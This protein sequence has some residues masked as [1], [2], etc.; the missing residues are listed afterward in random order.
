MSPDAAGVIDA[1]PL[2][3]TT[4]EFLRRPVIGHVIDGQ[5]FE[6]TNDATVNVFDPS[7]GSLIGQSAI[8]NQS[9][10]NRA[11][12][13]A[14]QAFDSGVWRNVHPSEREKRM[15]RFADLIGEH[16]ST[17]AQLDTLDAGIQSAFT[18]FYMN[19][20]VDMIHYFAGWPSKIHG[21]LPD[22]GSGVT[23]RLVREPIGVCAFVMPWN[24]P[25]IA[26]VY[27]VQALAT[28]NSVVL[29]PAEQ[30]PISAQYVGLLYAEAG[31]PAGVMNI[32]QGDGSTGAALVS[33]PDVAKV[34]FTGSVET[35][36]RIQQAAAA[37]LTPVDLELGGKSPNIV[38][39]DA[40]LDLAS[41]AAS[42]AVWNNSGQVCTAGTRVLVD[43]AVHDEFVAAMI[44]KSKNIVLGG[45]FDPATQM[46]PLIT[47]GQLDRVIDYVKI[48]ND[49]GAH[50]AMGGSQPDGLGG[51]FFEPTIF[52]SVR[53]DMRIA[54]EEIFGPVM[55]V[56]PFDNEEHAYEIANDSE[57]GLA[58]GVWTKDIDRAD[59]ASRNLHVGT[60]WI[61]TYQENDSSVPYGG[62][63]HSG[64]GRTMGQEAVESFTHTKSVWI[65]HH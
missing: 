16:A 34:Y 38:F 4:R 22:L 65:R 35:G 57:Y 46:G 21:R 41:S 49:E 3:D 20:A 33:H 55:S 61:N 17:I 10:V 62:M 53:N 32:L 58:A 44:E 39:A 14:K 40:D 52:D 64:F 36:K 45:A 63:K 30:A 59:R 31:I 26:A 9:D 5:A 11:V 47:A 19:L 29:K 43:R 48:G 2:S 12:A 23:V 8:A 51:Y 1:Y 42:S 54:Q 25:G 60:V 24:G 56:I 7:S 27:P 50:L 37:N 18:S 13:S 15:H 28:G 6:G